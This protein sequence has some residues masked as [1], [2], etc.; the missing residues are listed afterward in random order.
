[1]KVARS[2]GWSYAAY[3]VEA[4]VGLGVVAFVVRRVGIADYGVLTLALSIASLTAILDLGLL[5]LLVQAC[6]G[7]REKG[8]AEAVGRLVSAALRWLALA[9]LVAVSVC[10]VIALT[11]PGPFNI[12]PGLVHPAAFCLMLSGLAVALSLLG[13]GLEMAHAAAEAFGRISRIQIVVAL[14]RAVMTLVIIGS[15]FGIVALAAI[16]VAAAG[17][18]LVL[19][20]S[21]VAQHAGALGVSFRRPKLYTLDVLWGK[22]TWATGDNIARQAAAAANS[23]VLGILT[24]ASVVAIFGVAMRVPGHLMA[25]ANRGISVTLPFLS[26][27]HERDEQLELRELFVS[28]MTVALAILVPV[29][30]IGIAFAPEIVSVI[31][32]PSYSAAAPVLRVLLLATLVQGFSIPAYQVLYARG[33][34]AT[35]ARIGIS[36]SVANIIL[37]V[38]LAA[39]YG[40]L[41]A[42]WATAVTHIAGTVGWYLPAALRSAGLTVGELAGSMFRTALRLRPEIPRGSA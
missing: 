15:G 9:G 21:G 29:C 37:T 13:T 36:E 14:T 6:V 17:L 28:T 3:A 20:Y 18:R 30:A 42:A 31:A 27:Q 7:E 11:L 4:V 39:R 10:A 8:G 41:G 16:H 5:G 35:A 2:V 38:I 19:L 12:E 24:T 40:A 23:I 32:G 34:I 22:R 25:L 33:E 26:R 1:M